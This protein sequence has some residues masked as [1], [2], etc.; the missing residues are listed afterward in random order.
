MVRS[1][2]APVAVEGDPLVLDGLERGEASEVSI[3][4]LISLG[5]SSVMAA[6]KEGGLRSVHY[7]DRAAFNFLGIFAKYTTRVAGK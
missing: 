2:G 4:G 5:D 1:G 7:V 3:L 6:A